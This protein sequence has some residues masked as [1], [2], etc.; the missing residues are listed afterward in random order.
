MYLTFGVF[1]TLVKWCSIGLG[2]QEIVSLLV[3]S[4]DP[5][6]HY[7]DASSKTSA[8]RLMTCKAD[9]PVPIDHW[10]RESSTN[11][12]G[13]LSEIEVSKE[14][15]NYFEKIVVKNNI[16]RSMKYDLIY[17]LKAVLA[18]DPWAHD[19]CKETFIEMVGMTAAEF[20]ACQ[21]FDLAKSLA[22]L[23]LYTIMIRNNTAGADTREVVASQSFWDGLSRGFLAFDDRAKTLRVVTELKG[24]D[25]YFATLKERFGSVK[26]ILPGYAIFPFDDIF[27]CNNIENPSMRRKGD[28]PIKDATVDILCKYGIRLILRAYGGNGKTMMFRHFLFDAIKRIDVLNTVPLFVFLRH[29]KAPKNG[30]QLVENLTSYIVERVRLYWPQF[31][32]RIL[33]AILGSKKAVLLLDGLDE[34]PDDAFEKFRVDLQEFVNHYPEIQIIMSARPYAQWLNAITDFTTVELCSFTKEQ[35][36]ELVDKIDYFPKDP[37]RDMGF[38]DLIAEDKL[39]PSQ[40]EFYGNPLLLIA[41][42]MVYERKSQIPKNKADFFDAI[43]TMLTE[44]HDS[45]K[46]GYLRTYA[47]GLERRTLK[48]YLAEFAYTAYTDQDWM[49]TMERCEQIYAGLSCR[50]GE[51]VPTRC[52]DFMTDVVKN[53]SIM[54]EEGGVFN[55]YQHTFQEYFCAFHLANLS[56]SGMEQLIPTFEESRDRVLGDSM[57]SMMYSISPNQVEET[58]LLPV[59]R[60]AFKKRSEVE[61]F[62]K[63]R[64]DLKGKKAKLMTG[65]WSYVL[66]QYPEIKFRKYHYKENDIVINPKSLFVEFVLQNTLVEVERQGKKVIVSIF[67]EDLDT[68]FFPDD[69]FV[70]EESFYDVEGRILGNKREKA[71]LVKLIDDN[72]EAIRVYDDFLINIER[73]MNPACSSLP[74]VVYMESADFPLMKEYIALKARF[75]AMKLKRA[76]SRRNAEARKKLTG[77]T[78][79][80]AV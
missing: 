36:I 61:S 80:D 70:I 63:N 53:L 46:G 19:A 79:S 11:I 52:V 18:E 62:I 17:A 55:F 56:A 47:T 23:F 67:H 34:M 29:Y 77:Q 7:L 21:S 58:Y 31:D 4:I 73:L 68:S 26:T 38:R 65:Y 72:H 69:P 44:K 25:V 41:M 64:G 14:F 66:N 30:E 13:M 43:Y 59:L 75:E 32:E 78:V 71:M 76:R 40:R 9:F 10:E 22:S 45:L 5:N 50:S 35:A 1:A 49:L 74:T 28:N 33:R 37:D 42:L 48:E 57:F 6:E 27:V 12:M 2:N 60:K 24:L 16:N 39:S 8:S 51:V 15:I 3:R 54:Y 20:V